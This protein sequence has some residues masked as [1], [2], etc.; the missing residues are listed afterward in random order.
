MA[1]ETMKAWAAGIVDGEGWIALENR[2]GRKKKTPI[3]EVANTNMSIL[4]Q[5]ADNFGGK[6]Y[7]H[8]K[9]PRPN[10]K[11][12]WRWRLR[13]RKC[14]VFLKEIKTWLVGK[15]DRADEVIKYGEYLLEK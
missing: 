7:V 2:K 10:N 3:I 6:I 15:K 11:L 1:K 8:S 13:G 5:L 9:L 4:K 12:C 14:V